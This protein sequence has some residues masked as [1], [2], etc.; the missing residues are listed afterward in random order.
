MD[1]L[2]VIEIGEC[3]QA[4]VRMRPHIDAL[5]ALELGR[6]EMIEENER[7][8]GAAKRV[9]QRAADRE[10]IEIDRARDDDDLERVTGVRIAGG[11]VFSR[12]ETHGLSSIAVPEPLTWCVSCMSE[13]A[14][15]KS[16]PGGPVSPASE[17]CRPA[18]R[19]SRLYLRECERRTR[20]HRDNCG[21]G[22]D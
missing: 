16:N 15:G 3:R 11:G 21:W 18:M 9:W 12:K 13:W 5:P 20:R 4:D 22:H 8:D 17:V 1:D 14:F 6:A 10:P 7:S 19:Q 2:T